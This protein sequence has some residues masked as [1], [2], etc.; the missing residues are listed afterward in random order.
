MFRYGHLSLPH[1]YL[2]EKTQDKNNMNTQFQNSTEPHVV[3]HYFHWQYMCYK[4][5]TMLSKK[6]SVPESTK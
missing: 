3:L 4:N 6:Y 1:F 2:L 5:C